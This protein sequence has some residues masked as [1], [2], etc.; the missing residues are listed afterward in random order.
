M[1]STGSEPREPLPALNQRPL[2]CLRLA[3]AD[4]STAMAAA[5]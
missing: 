4:A 1:T 3:A 5:S 2:P